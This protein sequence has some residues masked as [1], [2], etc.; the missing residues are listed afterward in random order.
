MIRNLHRGSL[1]IAL[2][3]LFGMV[4]ADKAGAAFGAKGVGTTTANFLKLGVGARCE[5]MGEACSALTNDA[6]ALYWNPAALTLIPEKEATLMVMHAPYLEPTYFDFAGY[7]QNAGTA[8]AF[9]LG[10]QY[11]TGGAITR[12]DTSGASLGNFT[13]YDLAISLG[14]AKSFYGY[15]F[16]TTGKYVESKLQTSAHAM[17]VDLGLL[18]PAY[19]HDRLRLAVVETNLGGRMTFDEQS[20]ELPFNLKAGGALSLTPAWKAAF[21]VNFPI[22]NNPY[23]TIGSEYVW[24]IRRDWAMA[25]RIGY[26][27]RGS[28]DIEG[29]SGPTA[30]LGLRLQSYSFDYAV[31]P[32]GALGMTHR[33]SFS[34]RFFTG[35][36]N[37]ALRKSAEAMSHDEQRTN[38]DLLLSDLIANP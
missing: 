10:M 3:I 37:K 30:G 28:G 7:A 31:V 29:L 34:M 17:A 4:A 20:F 15:S 13:V 21:D 9:G 1:S 24:T 2:A 22:D 6:G 19:F 5:A 32:M 11:F 8:G 25:G 26:N 16:G 33:I 36:L 27:G 18:T 38:N 12:T 14:Y 23:A 35:A